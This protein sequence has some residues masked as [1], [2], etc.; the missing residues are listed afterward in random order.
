[1]ELQEQ[2]DAVRSLKTSYGYRIRD[3]EEFK[4]R[5]A[6]VLQICS[7]NNVLFLWLSP[8]A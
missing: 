7:L 6:C 5:S 8:Q 1:M 3:Q 2:P 4:V